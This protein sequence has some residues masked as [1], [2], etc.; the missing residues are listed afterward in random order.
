MKNNIKKDKSEKRIIRS[1]FQYINTNDRIL[2]KMS[3]LLK[4]IFFYKL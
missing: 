1:L 2:Y 3:F 4:K